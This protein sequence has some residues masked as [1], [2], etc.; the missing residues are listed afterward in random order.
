MR[1]VLFSIAVLL[2]ALVGLLVL[3]GDAAE[4][5]SRPVASVATIAA[6]VEALRELR[7]SR[8]PVPQGVSPEQARRE[9]LEDLDRAY[10]ASRRKAD[11]EVL[12]LLGLIEPGVDLREISGSVFGEGVAGYYDPRSKRL[13]IVSGSTP[14]ALSEMV[15]AHELVHA[16]EDQRFGLALEEGESDDAALARLALVEGSATL[17]MQQYLLR[18]IGAEQALGGLLGSA[19]Q[20]GP[21]LPPFLQEQLIFPYLSGMVFVQS[22]YA[23]GGWK[24]VDLADRSRVPES[25]EQILHP[26]KWVEAEG[27][28]PVELDVDLGA[29]W[30][31]TANGTWGEWQTREL[32]GGGADEAAAGW[33]GDRYE[34]WQR[35]SCAQAPC[36]AD[37]ALV[38]KWRWDSEKDAVE[39]ERALRAAEVANGA[40]VLRAGDTVTFVL[41]ADAALARR[42]A[43][44]S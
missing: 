33:G 31:R 3:E 12:K 26:E 1:V 7:F 10:P 27:P 42:L 34:L 39:F 17:V 43:S 4:R 5:P 9:G 2:V 20:T 22:L 23:Q 38:M 29:G 21:D 40:A 24:L 6:R 41:A 11:E 44:E 8:R 37:D 15:L 32:L 30:R 35:G 16:L 13:R 28:L 36:R 19:M 25:T 18:H 14:D